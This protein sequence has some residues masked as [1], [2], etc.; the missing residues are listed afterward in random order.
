MRLIGNRSLIPNRFS[1]IG[2]CSSCVYNSLLSAPKPHLRS[3]CFLHLQ[4]HVFFQLSY[5][6]VPLRDW[7]KRNIQW[8]V[9]VCACT[10]S[11]AHVCIYTL[12]SRKLRTSKP[13]GGFGNMCFELLI[14]LWFHDI[15]RYFQR[16][17]M[18]TFSPWIWVGCES[19]LHSTILGNKRH[20][21]Q[22]RIQMV[23]FF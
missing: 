12:S 18:H 23:T 8:C 15:E 10:R 16:V 5:E 20:K 3:T 11:P 2:F 6:L 1:S 17:R 13:L 4:I 7:G 9:C 22:D 21:I 14:L 19:Q